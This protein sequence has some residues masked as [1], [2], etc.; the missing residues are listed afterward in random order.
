[1]KV[2]SRPPRPPPVTRSEQRGKA[3]G[4]PQP[5]P[6]QPA[7][8]HDDEGEGAEDSEQAVGE[9]EPA[10]AEQ[11]AQASDEPPL[12]VDEGGR[13]L[14]E[15]DAV[16]EQEGA[17]LG[18]LRVA[19]VVVEVVAVVEGADEGPPGRRVESGHHVGREGE[20]ED[21]Q[22]D[23][24]QEPRVDG[25]RSRI[26][27]E[28]AGAGDRGSAARRSGGRPRTHAPGD[29]GG[30]AWELESGTCGRVLKRS[31]ACET[32]GPATLRRPCCCS[33]RWPRPG[34]LLRNCR[35]IAGP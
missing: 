24:G 12:E 22:E 34:R 4:S 26:L 7:I 13:V 17:V 11:R 28:G 1:M 8:G 2:K 31:F 30:A 3:V 14:L 10:S 18:L 33:S 32:H 21:E 25:H 9:E 27:P 15:Q 5:E 16:L 19:E 6:A 29:C 20:R 35:R 23:E